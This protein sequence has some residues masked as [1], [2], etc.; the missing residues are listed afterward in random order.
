M[1]SYLD[2]CN[3]DAGNGLYHEILCLLL[4]AAIALPN[5]EASRLSRND[6]VSQNN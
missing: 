3:L 2:T 4:L 6:L 1:I 5:C